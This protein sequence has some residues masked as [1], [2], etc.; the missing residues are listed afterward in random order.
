MHITKKNILL[1]SSVIIIVLLAAITGGSFYMLSYSLSPDKTRHNTDSCYR[2]LFERYPETAEW[3]DSLKRIDALRD[4]FITMPTGER[5]HAYFVNRGC[6]RTALVI[7]GWRD[8]A[9]KYFF[10][11][12]M[13]EHDLDYNVVMPDLHASGMSD[14]KAIGMGWNDRHDVMQW[15]KA[16]KSDTMVV[17]GVSM[18][19]A[20]TMMMSSLPMP[21]GINDLRFVEDCGYTSVWEEFSGELKSQFGL[22]EF[23][24]MYTTSLLCKMRY[25]WSFGEA[26]AIGEVAKCKYP[27]L[28]IHGDKD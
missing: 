12:R 19:A 2:E 17:H 15:L 7:H 4:T 13:Y 22:P 28:F 26:S 14:G 24:L 6:Q 20:T 11:A 1:T 25:G 9:I 23:P 5:H 27:M 10:L 16:F 3:I 8:Q 21:D 18:G